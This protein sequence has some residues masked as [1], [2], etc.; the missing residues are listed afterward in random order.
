MKNITAVN[1]EYVVYDPIFVVPVINLPVI[2]RALF[3]TCRVAGFFHKV[4]YIT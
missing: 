3:W 1:A 2:R 4:A